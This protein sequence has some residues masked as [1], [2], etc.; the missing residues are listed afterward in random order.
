MNWDSQD[1]LFTE[2]WKNMGFNRFRLYVLLRVII[3][4][5]TVTA[6]VYLIYFDQKYVTTVVIGLVIIFEVFELFQYIER[7]NRRLKRFFD[8]IKYNDFNTSFAEDNKLGS[9]FRELNTAFKDVVETIQKER[10][11]REEFFQ[12]LNTVVQHI[13]TGILSINKQ[14]KVLLSNKA[15]AALLEVRE[16]KSIRGLEQ[17]YPNIP[18]ILQQLATD[19]R[20][21]IKNQSGQELALLETKYRLGE[22]D[23]QL[24]AIQNIHAEMQE[25]EL[26]AWQNL[27][28]V[29]RHEIMNSIAPIS[30][31]TATLEDVLKEEVQTKNDEHLLNS[32][33]LE[34]L[35]EG[36]QTISKRSKGLIDFI[37]AYRDYTDLPKPTFK[38]TDFLNTIHET[39]MLVKPD[40]ESAEIAFKFIHPENPVFIGIDRQLIELVLI[41]ILK[42]AL[43][44]IRDRPIRKVELALEENK[45]KVFLK[46]S[47]TGPGIAKEA[48]EKIF[49]PFYTTKKQGSGIGLSLSKQIIQMHQAS[50]SVE[51]APGKGST[52]I[53]S[54][55]KI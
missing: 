1:H 21:R 24:I 52:F 26:E 43:E 45:G 4:F 2:D 54:F 27:T 47:D 13:G 20:A 44:A 48:M 16:I 18:R 30:S 32:E 37:N 53:L 19:Q 17:S 41:N 49:L 42:N 23:Y 34:D 22:T 14:G 39:L 7:T 35:Q 8:A 12:Q 6:F 29:L 50:I 5:I 46:I 51:T 9:T 55:P 28:K 38:K 15:A 10:Q 36:L 11:K 3:L 33:G 25:K 31:L 40:L